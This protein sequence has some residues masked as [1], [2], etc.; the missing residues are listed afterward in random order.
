MSTLRRFTQYIARPYLFKNREKWSRRTLFSLGKLLIA[1]FFLILAAYAIT[2]LALDFFGVE[3]PDQKRDILEQ[4]TTGWLFLIILLLPFIEELFFRSWLRKK[5]GILYILPVFFIVSW[6]VLSRMF[7]D[8]VNGFIFTVL[9][10][11]AIIYVTLISRLRS[12]SG[13][14]DTLIQSLFPYAFWG[15]TIIFALM[16]LSNFAASQMGLL[17][18]LLVLPQFISG[19]FYAYICGRFGFF[20]AF[21]CHAT[22]NGAIMCMALQ[23]WKWDNFF[24]FLNSANGDNWF[25]FGFQRYISVS[26]VF[27]LKG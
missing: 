22:W 23:L 5:W 6:C 20:A 7:L 8:E 19:T 11:F 18:V 3:K 2:A 17:A 10:I 24:T 12:K 4:L 26:W 16:H 1:K 14:A 15:S 21:G 25:I 13:N 9:V 27:G